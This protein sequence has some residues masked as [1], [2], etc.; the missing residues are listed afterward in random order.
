MGCQGVFSK[1]QAVTGGDNV[2]SCDREKIGNK[3]KKS[4]TEESEFTSTVIDPIFLIGT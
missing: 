2:Q 1:G 3:D 4:E